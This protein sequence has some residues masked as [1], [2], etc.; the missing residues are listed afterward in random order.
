M[1]CSRVCE[2]RVV[3]RAI[4][5]ICVLLCSRS[6]FC[7][8]F[9]FIFCRPSSASFFAFFFLRFRVR[10]GRQPCL[11]CIAPLR[12][13][14][15]F[16]STAWHV[17]GA[18]CLA[19]IVAVRG[20]GGEPSNDDAE[21]FLLSQ[22]C[23]SVLLLRVG[24]AAGT[25]CLTL[26]MW[27]VD[28]GTAV[29]GTRRTFCGSFCMSRGERYLSTSKN[30]FSEHHDACPCQDSRE[31]LASCWQIVPVMVTVTAKSGRKGHDT[32]LAWSLFTLNIR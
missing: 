9:F 30:I 27:V 5:L 22:A 8:C 17:N 32:V 29:R 13:A 28:R 19:T 10:V 26:T 21:I 16:P 20:G 11:H 3:A 2:G 15:G 4:G 7:R 18:I 31:R 25:G 24:R 1:K 23:F 6:V 14:V 12:F